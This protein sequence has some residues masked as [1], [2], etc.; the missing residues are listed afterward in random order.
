MPAAV[1][2][3]VLAM[4]GGG[5]AKR[6]CEIALRAEARVAFDASRQAGGDL[7]EQPAIAVGIPERGEG[8]VAAAL[9]IRAVH[10]LASEQILLVGADMHVAGAVK[11]FADLDAAG[12]QIVAGGFDV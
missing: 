6:C 11:G 8:A 12:D 3:L 7:L 5:A 9:R 2:L 4:G 1:A 10:A